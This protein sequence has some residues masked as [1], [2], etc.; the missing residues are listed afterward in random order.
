MAKEIK[1]K[2]VN[3]LWIGDKLSP[4]NIV[5]IN[6]F[7]SLDYQYNLY[8]YDDIEN[9]PPNVNLLDGN[10]I[11]PDS[12]IWYYGKGFNKGSPSAFSNEFRYKFLYEMGGLYCDT[13]FVLLK[14][15][16]FHDHDYVLAQEYNSKQHDYIVVSTFL[17]YSKH[18]NQKVFEECMNH[19][20]TIDRKT[21]VHGQIGPMLLDA[22]AHK[23]ELWGYMSE[24]EKFTAVARGWEEVENL[25]TEKNIPKDAYGI[26]LWNAMW[27]N[28]DTNL[29]VNFINFPKDCVWEQLKRKYL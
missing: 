21:V 24:V 26:H 19:T 7:L 22:Y 20:D 1:D 29:N 13:D 27:N 12:G 14:D 15:F 4:I 3:S 8:T 6:S 18:K 25:I 23:N 17:I 5:S 11:L 2:V 16:D 28:P 9:V 10:D